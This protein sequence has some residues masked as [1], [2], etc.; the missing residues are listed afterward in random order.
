MFKR[1]VANQFAHVQRH[2]PG[3]GRVMG[4]P[5][6]SHPRAPTPREEHR[7]P[8]HHQGEHSDHYDG[9]RLNF[10]GGATKGRG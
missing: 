8:S 6:T 2:R 7:R 3:G 10:L 9:P 4:E 1:L 5:S